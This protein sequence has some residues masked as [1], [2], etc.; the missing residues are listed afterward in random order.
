MRDFARVLRGVFRRRGALVLCVCS[1]VLVALLWGLNISAIFPLIEVVFEGHGAAGYVQQRI[2]D[3]ARLA[4]EKR[5]EAQTLAGQADEVDA[6]LAALAGPAASGPAASGPAGSQAGDSLRRLQAEL[7]SLRWQQE[8]ATRAAEAYE[9]SASRLRSIEPYSSRYLPDAPYPTLVFLVALLVGGTLVKLTALTI[10]QLIVQDLSQEAAL[11]VREQFFRKALRHDPEHY[12]DSG[13]AGFTSRLTGDVNDL[14]MGVSIVL[15]RLLREPLK[16]IVCLVGAGLVCWRLLLLIMIIAPL[17][18]FVI[19]KLSRSIRRTSRRVMEEMTELYGMLNETFAGIVVVRAYNTEAQQRA[20]FR[21]SARQYYRKSMKVTFYN[22][23]SRFA[24]ESLGTSMMCVGL[25]AAGYLVLNREVAIFGIPMSDT[26]LSVT[27]MILFFGLL[28][29]ASDPAQKL[30]DVWSNLQR[31]IAAA[32]RLME[33]IDQPVRVTDPPEPKTVPRPH[34]RLSLKNVQ[35]RYPSGPLVLRNLNLEIPHGESWA[36][37]GPNGS[38]KSTL[39]SLLC[40]FDDPLQ[41]TVSLDGVS[42]RQM[43]VRD[44]RRRIG[45]VTQRTVVFE[46]TILN[47]IRFGSPGATREAAIRAAQQAFADEFIC[48]RMPDGYETKIGGR[49]VRLS[50]GQMQRIALARA[51]LRDPEILILDEATSQIDLESERLIHDA[52]ATFLVGRTGI[53]ITHRPS[54]LA[55]VDKIAVI[56]AGEVSDSGSLREVA[57]RNPFLRSLVDSSAAKA[58]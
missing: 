18:G 26:P 40:R 30:G 37:V 19:Q 9:V 22:A 8:L 16:M 35:F 54:T 52:L 31:G 50:G 48:T 34:R 4:E 53:M 56:E 15:G 27:E 43:R 20:R 7:R 1:S 51:F 33:V 42:L 10:N 36:I 11:Q 2:D 38:G 25:L 29:G 57:L 49:G 13:A 39:V 55:L 45:L 21:R 5:T 47:N 58:A 17:V 6:K 23:A 3:A 28:I 46:E 12:G 24:N 32:E 14:S 41:G 44:V